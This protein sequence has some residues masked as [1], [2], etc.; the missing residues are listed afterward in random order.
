[1]YQERGTFIFCHIPVGLVH[2]GFFI[3][4]KYNCT[5]SRT[6]CYYYIFLGNLI[7]LLYYSNSYIK[8]IQYVK[9]NYRSL[10]TMFLIWDN[11]I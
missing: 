1:M 4:K 6:S 3:N 8:K 11:F 7:F 5:I 10:C 9:F 2:R